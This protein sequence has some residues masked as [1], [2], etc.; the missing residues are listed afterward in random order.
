M[1][2]TNWKGHMPIIIR[3]DALLQL[4]THCTMYVPQ[5]VQLQ[6]FCPG[7]KFCDFIVYAREGIH[8]ERIE[9]NSTF[10]NDNL[11]KAKHCLICL[12]I[13]KLTSGYYKVKAL[14]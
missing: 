14:L 12:I 13:I 1:K 8:V 11:V 2:N 9:L 7:A 4:T 6:L 10:L 5:Q 3:Y